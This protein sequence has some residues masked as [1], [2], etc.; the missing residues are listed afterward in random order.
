MKKATEAT[1]MFMILLVV[2]LP[3]CFAQEQFLTVYSVSKDGTKDYRAPTDKTTVYAEIQETGVRASL[4]NLITPG[5]TI[6]FSTCKFESQKSICTYV[7]KEG[8][9]PGGENPF[10]VYYKEAASGSIIVDNSTPVVSIVSLDSAEKIKVKYH[11]E[12][13]AYDS[14]DQ[15]KCSGI[16]TVSFVLSG[17]TLKLLQLNLTPDTLCN[18]DS[19]IIELDAPTTKGI[20]RSFCVEVTDNV[21]NKGTACQDIIVDKEPAKL[22]TVELINQDGKKINFV[23]SKLGPV[24]GAKIRFTLLDNSLSKVVA[25]ASEFT[26]DED[27]KNNQRNVDVTSSCSP[28]PCAGSCICEVPITLSLPA[29]GS[30]VLRL[31]VLDSSGNSAPLNSVVDV[32]A[33]NTGPS[34]TSLVAKQCGSKNALG[35]TGNTLTA[36]INEAESGLSSRKVIVDLSKV[37]KS[38]NFAQ[39]YPYECKQTGSQWACK[40]GVFDIN[41]ILTTGDIVPI[42]VV[43]PSQDNAGNAII[44]LADNKFF[45]DAS[46][47]VV[48]NSSVYGASNVAFSGDISK[49]PVGGGTMTLTIEATDDLPLTATADFS[50]V[51]K[52]KK[53]TVTCTGTDKQSCKFV[54]VGPLFNLELTDAE[55]PV[56]ITDCVGNKIQTVQKVSISVLSKEG[57]QNLFEYSPGD[58]EPAKIDRPTLKFFDHSAY[59]PLTITSYADPISQQIT[60]CAGNA[61]DYLAFNLRSQRL[62]EIVAGPSKTPYLKFKFQAGKTPPDSLTLN[63]T[64]KTIGRVGGTIYVPE[65]DNIV[66]DAKFY[67]N[68]MGSIDQALQNKIDNLKNSWLVKG[69][70]IG[71]LDKWIGYASDFCGVYH[72]LLNIALI[73]SSTDEILGALQSTPLF[74]ISMSARAADEANKGTLASISKVI[75]PLCN[76]I[77][78]K[79][80]PFVGKK[81]NTFFENYVKKTVL[82]VRE[83]IKVS[84]IF[85]GFGSSGTVKDL[86]VRDSLILSATT[87]CL[88]GVLSGLQ[89]ARAVEC[90]YIY[91]VKTQ[92]PNGVPPYLCDAV[93]A[94]AMCQFVYGEIFQIV[95]FAHFADEMLG[96]VKQAVVHDPAFIFSIALTACRHSPWN[97]IA[98]ACNIAA[99]LSQIASKAASFSAAKSWKGVVRMYFHPR[100]DSCSL[101]DEVNPTPPR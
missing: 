52:V 100:Y 28:T 95:P 26:V 70:I 71:M 78:C 12:E 46:A 72:T 1:A 24:F 79:S 45:F 35:P 31:N 63:C 17:K 36:T 19:E 89:R 77:E 14:A 62:P 27:E 75:D 15:S 39:V 13:R 20:S 49:Y 30:P 56:E 59:V 97:H 6:P 67:E 64:I 93:R 4:I 69:K 38:N 43:Y 3:F 18:Y 25:D 58:I 47:P 85:G 54:E 42:D 101:I 90:N 37:M 33:D 11:V 91:C 32:K 53:R 29:G 16:R 34:V 83:P 68:S 92:V 81:I 5:A 84:K 65:Y 87:L 10:Q 50:K 61:A 86:D 40:W 2:S 7:F 41:N 9:W 82:F 73:I 99:T 57:Q 66:V 80:I 76:A 44:P 48:I 51:S 98:A 8:L 23:S 74:M 22:S 88:P 55:I 60:S 94:S 21:G 96:F